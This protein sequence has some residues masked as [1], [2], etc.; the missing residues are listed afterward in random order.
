MPLI[1]TAGHVD[2]GKSTLIER[3]T[4]R[5]PDRWEEEK[6]RG[7]TIDLGFAWTV[8]PSGTEVSFVDVP[9]HERYLKNML[10]GVE[11]IDVALFVV[12][13]DEGWMPQSEEHLAVLDLLDVSR[14]VVTLT[15]RD[16]VDDE[17]V[18]LSAMEV[19]D[20]L[21]GT[22]LGGSPIIPVSA[23]Q[24]LGIDELVETL[25]DL[26]T[27]VDPPDVG[28]PRLWIDRSFSVRGAGTV[29]TGTLLGGRLAVDEEVAVYPAGREVRIRGIQ[30]HERPVT[31]VG[32]G[33]RVALNLSGIDH[34][35]LR[36][37]DMVGRPNQ[38][39]LSTRFSAALRTPRY[40]EDLVPRGAYQLHIGSGTHQMRFLGI[41]EGRAVVV[42]DSPLPV[43]TGDPFIVRDTGRRLVTAGGRVLDPSPGATRPALRRAPRLDPAATPETIA[44]ALL[45][46]RGSDSAARLAA[47]SRGGRPAAAIQVGDRF[48]APGEYR[49]LADAVHAMV[50]EQHRAHALR[51]GAPLATL[52]EHLGV[53]QQ[54]VERIVADSDHLVRIGP[55]VAEKGHRAELPP[56]AAAD[57]KRAR[58]VLS[59]SLAVPTTD[60]LGLDPEVLHLL[61]RRDEL[62][63]VSGQLVYLPEQID[64]IR[65]HIEA[66][67]SGFRVADFRDATGLSRKY[68]VP[69][70]EWADGEGL[71]Q[72]TGDT[73]RPS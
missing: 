73:R 64:Q 44:G 18:E 20:R 58:E 31:E 29:V 46:M 67:G 2:H 43:T 1:G 62:V 63:R 48:L 35:E 38:W 39:D 71:T 23:I 28:R 21:E 30:T 17:I 51:P 55:D 41:E 42:T 3:L 26:V 32:P 49:R 7:L 9:G 8:L 56:S 22:S 61:L 12:A 60:E 27:L 5:D 65:A 59:L 16:L 37:G 69:I 50:A 45:E 70:L 6:R 33:R 15:K 11:T 25:D 13:A 57:W 10:A 47:H 40:V 52:A 54:T 24:G 14:G 36:R 72:R 19:A 53:S 34:R 66:M 4:G 68:A